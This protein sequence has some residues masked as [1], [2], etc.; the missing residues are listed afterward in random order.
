MRGSASDA[1][2]L[3]RPRRFAFGQ[4]S[5]SNGGNELV[6]TEIA[7]IAAPIKARRHRDWECASAI[8]RNCRESRTL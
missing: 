2:C 7:K 8:F 3:S 5:T 1:R 6:A 4:F